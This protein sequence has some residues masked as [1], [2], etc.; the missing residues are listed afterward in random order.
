[1]PSHLDEEGNKK[2]VPVGVVVSENDIKGNKQADTLAGI[3]A[4][5]VCGTI[6]FSLSN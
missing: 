2:V 1:M 6:H 3:A 5:R 4:K